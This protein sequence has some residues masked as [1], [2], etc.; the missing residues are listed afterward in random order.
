MPRP[1][2]T[3]QIDITTAIN[4]QLAIAIVATVNAIVLISRLL[5]S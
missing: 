2:C 1:P 5:I 4:V 3:A